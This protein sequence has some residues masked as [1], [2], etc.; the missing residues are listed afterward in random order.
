MGLMGRQETDR[1]DETEGGLSDGG[2]DG[3]GG[4]RAYKG[5]HD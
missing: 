4:E 3:Q 5:K 1:T 2:G